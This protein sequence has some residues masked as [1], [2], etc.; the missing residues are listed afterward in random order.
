MKT[1]MLSIAL[2]IWGEGDRTPTVSSL[3]AA[4]DAA[5]TAGFD[6]VVVS[7]HVVYGDDT[8]EYGNPATGGT[9]GGRQPTSPDGL[10]LEPMTVLAMAAARTTRVRL[11]TT[12]LLAPPPSACDPGQDRRDPRLPVARA[13]GFRCRCGLA[14]SGVRGLWARLR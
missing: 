1:P 5:E 13:I 11:G 2:P 3:L 12:I 14:A 9:E 7:E 10:W 4:I 8:S 6:R